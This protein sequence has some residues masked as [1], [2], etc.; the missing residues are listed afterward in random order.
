MNLKCKINGKEYELLVQGNTLSDELNE[1]LDSGNIILAHINKIKKLKPYDDVYIYDNE[2]NGYDRYGT[3]RGQNKF[4]KHLLVDNYTEEFINLRDKIYKYKIALMSEI[5]RMEK[6]QCPNISITQPLNPNK[7]VSVYEYIRRFVELYSPKYK[8]KNGEG[9]WEYRRKY[10]VDSSLFSIF[11]NVYPPDFSLNAPTLRDI[12][13]KL[14]ICKDMIPYVENDVI[15]AMDIT[16]RKNEINFENLPCTN[17]VSSMNSNDYCDSLR[18]NYSNALSQDSTCSSV[19]Y[20]GFRNSDSALMTLQNMRLETKF[21]IYKINKLYMCYYKKSNVIKKNEDGTNTN[22]Y[23]LCKQDIT[24]LIKLNTE[25]NALSK[26]WNDFE[27]NLPKNIEELAEYKLATL[28]YD[29]GSNH[30]TGFGEL[31]EYPKGWWS[32]E[33]RTY[34]E[35]ILRVVDSFDLTGVRNYDYLIKNIEEKEGLTI[36]S[37]ENVFDTIITPFST[38]AENNLNVA[39]ALDMKGLFF[40][41]DYQGFYNG[42]VIH[43]KDLGNDNIVSNDN[44]SSSLALLELDGLSQKEKVNRLGNKTYQFTV[45]YEKSEDLSMLLNLG[46]YFS[47]DE[48]DDIII[49]HREIAIYDNYIIATYFAA[50]DYVLKNYYTS[51]YARHRT[52]NLIPYGESVTRAENRKMYLY[53]S[54]E[55]SYYES[56][57]TISFSTDLNDKLLL[58]SII[59]SSEITAI[60]YYDTKDKINGG[61]ISHYSKDKDLNKYI[62]KYYLADVNGLVCGYSLCFNLKMFDNISMGSFISDVSPFESSVY[63]KDRKDFFDTKND[64]TGSNISLYK[65]VDDD[66]TGKIDKIGISFFHYDSS[67]IYKD[68]LQEYN[69]SNVE[70]EVK[71]IYEQNL[72]KLP[73]TN[74]QSEITNKLFVNEVLTKD[75]NN[76]E[77]EMFYIY[78]DNKEVIDMTYQIEPI[79]NDKNVLFSPWFMKLNDLLSNFLKLEYNFNYRYSSVESFHNLKGEINVYKSAHTNKVDDQ[80][81]PFIIFYL[82]PEDAQKFR[83]FRISFPYDNDLEVINLDSDDF[84]QGID[85]NS[86]YNTVTKLKL[87][88]L[89]LLSIEDVYNSATGKYSYSKIKWQVEQRVGI[90]FKGESTVKYYT[91]IEEYEFS[92]NAISISEH[93]YEVLEGTQYFGLQITSIK[94]KINGEEKVFNTTNDKFMLTNGRYES[95]DAFFDLDGKISWDKEPHKDY[96]KNMFV[97]TSEKTLRNTLVYDQYNDTNLPKDMCKY[98]KLYVSDIFSIEKDQYGDY[99]KVDLNI[100]KAMGT[101]SFK[102]QI[103]V[104]EE[105]TYPIEFYNDEERYIYIVIKESKVYY[106]KDIFGILKKEVYNENGWID[107]KYK[108]IQTLCFPLSSSIEKDKKEKTANYLNNNASNNIIVN[109]VQYWYKNIVNENFVNEEDNVNHLNFVFGVNLTEEDKQRG[110]VKVYASLISNRD[111]RVYDGFHNV[112]GSVTNYLSENNDKLYGENQYYDE[113]DI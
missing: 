95:K 48:E 52:W 22:Y 68:Y 92:S 53:L 90:I 23:F 104:S 81:R 89:K 98:E 70:N 83:E 57:K 63:K 71:N 33:K 56:E 10:S 40:E 80:Y 46:D 19:E 3:V 32:Q 13:S 107:S 97:I 36:S 112:I 113:E 20:L 66:E 64:Y 25:R 102:E 28:G 17:L 15:K 91:T 51:V 5:K 111:T 49:Y 103:D 21:P 65:I 31:Y 11:G 54:K 62:N 30:I 39:S 35:N 60:D 55:R 74:L 84:D 72:L 7:K 44:S 75:E 61:Y 26:D 73:K 94:T 58:S 2:F 77:E 42:S 87:K 18:R 79:T 78:K 6:I 76:I 88:F 45:K 82:S 34:L 101:L 110:Y 38:K 12:L 67:N 69:K 14:M 27:T 50:K 109:S 8:V 106:Y 43:S 100:L 41:I 9:T 108:T 93:P 59:P 86:L 24:P 4:Y 16:Q 96:S 47:Y 105:E 85:S 99:I 29:I 37:P 1:R